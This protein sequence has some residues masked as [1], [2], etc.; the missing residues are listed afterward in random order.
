MAPKRT[1]SIIKPDATAAQPHRR[2]QRRC[3]EDAGLRIVAQKRVRM[4]RREAEAFYAVHKRASV[5]RRAR[6]R[7]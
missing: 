3:I 4:S 2:H 6:R 5:L 1:F 7:S